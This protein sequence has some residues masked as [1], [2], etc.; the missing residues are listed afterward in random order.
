MTPAPAG[1]E[2][3]QGRGQPFVPLFNGRR[4]LL[5]VF[6][7]L[8]GISLI[9][10]AWRAPAALR[11]HGAGMIVNATICGAHSLSFSFRPTFG[12]ARANQRELTSATIGEWQV[13]GRR[14]FLLTALLGVAVL[15]PQKLVAQAMLSPETQRRIESVGACLTTPV[16]EKDDPRPC[17]TLQRRMAAL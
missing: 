17:Q 8:R 16:V 4:V 3:E 1:E 5:V 13:M 10:T 12:L 9:R 6:N 7:D 15:L 14:S 11:K 2:P